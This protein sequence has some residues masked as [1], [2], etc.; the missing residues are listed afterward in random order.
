MQM[1]VFFKY[2]QPEKLFAFTLLRQCETRKTLKNFRTLYQ[3]EKGQTVLREADMQEHL[4]QQNY[5][6]NKSHQLTATD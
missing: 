1:N 5:P 6:R 2:N 3:Q 4:E